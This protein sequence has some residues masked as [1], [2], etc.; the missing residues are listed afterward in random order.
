[1]KS[2]KPALERL[3]KTSGV[4]ENTTISIESRDTT[5]HLES[6]KTSRFVVYFNPLPAQFPPKVAG[7]I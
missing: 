5:F 1:M 3:F 7:R 2:G 4:P 6:N